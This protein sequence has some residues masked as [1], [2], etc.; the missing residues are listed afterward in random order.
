MLTMTVIITW[1]NPCLVVSWMFFFF[2]SCLYLWWNGRDLIHDKYHVQLLK[3]SESWV[4]YLSLFLMSLCL[5]S[6]LTNLKLSWSDCVASF[7]IKEKFSRLSRVKVCYVNWTFVG[8]FHILMYVFSHFRNWWMHWSQWALPTVLHW[9]KNI[10]F[11]L[12]SWRLRNRQ[13]G[14]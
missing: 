1:M 13:G 8:L 7:A 6:F 11:L 4:V 3:S 14:P 12:L 10:I 5:F 2:L 9:Y